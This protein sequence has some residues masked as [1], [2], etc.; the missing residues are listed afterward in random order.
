M[1]FGMHGLENSPN[2]E[3]ILDVPP[4]QALGAEHMR[5]PG[6]RCLGLG[7]LVRCLWSLIP[8]TQF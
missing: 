1:Y 2:K 4:H 6:Q 3:S 5:M 8:N 7:V